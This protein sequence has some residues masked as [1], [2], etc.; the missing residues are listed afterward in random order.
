MIE[1]VFQGNINYLQIMD[2]DGNLDLSQMPNDIDDFKILEMYKGMLLARALDRKMLSLQRQGRAVTYAPLLGEEATQIGSAYAMRKQDIFVPAFRQ[3]GVFLERGVPP[4]IMFLYWR[5]FEEGNILPKETNAFPIIVPVS[6]QMPH[7]V[8]IAFAQMYLKKDSA[9]VAYVGDG[10]T[11]EGDFYEALNFS[12]VWKAPLIVII[13]NNEW[14]ISLP[15]KEQTAAKTLAQK[16]V[17]AGVNAIQVDGND[18]LAV[19]KATKDAI[20][21]S[22]KGPTVIEC[23]TYRMGLHTTADDP[24]KY[25]DDKEV[26]EWKRRDPIQRVRKYLTN[27]GLWDDAKENNENETQ[28]K[29]ID[30]AV[31]KAEQFRPDPSSMFNSVYSFM[32]QNLREEFDSAEKNNFWQ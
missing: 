21:S 30:D 18:I 6:T 10:G 27:K 29:Y 25:R 15:R 2:P 20:N 24:T 5:G 9:V 19:Y 32:P 28:T 31:A 8:G 22:K 17:A 13:E 4:E 11:S 16:A 7:A 14:A 1:S 26:E 12:G 3:H 23:L